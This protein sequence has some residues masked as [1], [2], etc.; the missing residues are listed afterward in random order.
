MGS[1]TEPSPESLSVETLARERSQAQQP[2]AKQ[3]RSDK[4]MLEESEEKEQIVGLPDLASEN[5]AYG[6]GSQLSLGILYFI[7]S[8]K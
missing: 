6:Q 4:S 7:W 8:G 3:S 2:S 5:A 1:H